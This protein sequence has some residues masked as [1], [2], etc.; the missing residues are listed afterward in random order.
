MK[1]VVTK[2]QKVPKQKLWIGNY[3]GF[4]DNRTKM[5]KA[6]CAR[7]KIAR[8]ATS[9]GPDEVAHNEPP[10]LDL[11]CLLSSLLILN[12]LQNKQN[13]LLLNFADA[14][15]VVCFLAL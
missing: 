15:F 7:E 5:V 14:N 2:L 4:C 11:Y 1:L 10:Y 3:H 6:L 13:I 12:I 8:F 9:V